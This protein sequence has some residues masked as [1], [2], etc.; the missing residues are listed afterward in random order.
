LK[1]FAANR[2]AMQ[3]QAGIRD[4]LED[5][6]EESGKSLPPQLDAWTI[7]NGRFAAKATLSPREEPMP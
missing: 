4:A 5:H 7:A 3:R 2:N 1:S 6:G